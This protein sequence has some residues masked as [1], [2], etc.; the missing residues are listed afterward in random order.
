VRINQ[1]LA[2]CGLG[3][4]RKTEQ[5]VLAGV[6]CVNGKKIVDLSTRINPGDEVLLK[7]K[8]VEPRKLVYYVLNKPKG[9]TCTREDRFAKKLVTELVPKD[10][11]VFPVGRLDRESEGLIILT[12]DGELAEQLTHPKFDHEKEYEITVGAKKDQLLARAKKAVNLFA[13]GIVID[14]YRT[15]KAKA[16]FNV[17]EDG[18]AKFKVILKE[19]RKRQIRNTLN[20]AGLEVFE[21]KRVRIGRLT[22]GDLEEGK[23]KNI[24]PSQIL[25]LPR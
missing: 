24:A 12:N 23:Y 25:D 8:Q 6:V 1:Y 21:L 17:I 5:L 13:D 10:P 20:Q 22:L 4:R 19:G 14:G 9:Y 18:R 3:S 7:D 15:K 2:K 16:E 11:P